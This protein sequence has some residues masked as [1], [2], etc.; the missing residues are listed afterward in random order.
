MHFK[1][2]FGNCFLFF[3]LQTCIWM[4]LKIDIKYNIL[5]DLRI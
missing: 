2:M 5:I 3:V 4:V 1:N